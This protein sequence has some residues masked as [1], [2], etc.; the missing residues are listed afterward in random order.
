[1]VLGKQLA[2]PV[3]FGGGVGTVDF[4]II[5]ISAGQ[6]QLADIFGIE[7]GA[8]VVVGVAVLTID[9]IVAVRQI[10]KIPLRGNLGG[11]AGSFLGKCPF[12]V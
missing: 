12:A 1:M 10:D 2:V 8:A 4:E 11:N 9:G 6:I 3:D 7:G 5:A